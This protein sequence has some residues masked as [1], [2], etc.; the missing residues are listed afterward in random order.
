M[1]KQSYEP[2]LCFG[3]GAIR[4]ESHLPVILHDIV[5][6]EQHVPE[7]IAGEA[8]GMPAEVNRMESPV[9][10]TSKEEVIE[11]KSPAEI[12]MDVLFMDSHAG[13]IEIAVQVACAKEMMVSKS[14]GIHPGS[15]RSNV[16]GQSIR[17]ATPSASTR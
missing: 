11:G 1:F 17:N 13:R 12:I 14:Y 2:L 9:T 16:E 5:A 4:V 15:E 3:L 8:R 7:E 10:I 6:D